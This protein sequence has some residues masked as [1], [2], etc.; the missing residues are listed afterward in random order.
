[1]KII[2][3]VA[4]SPLP[5]NEAQVIDSF[6]TTDD[7]TINA[8]SINI[9][10]ERFEQVEEKNM[11]T[12]KMMSDYT[13]QTTDTAEDIEAFSLYNSIGNKL[14]IDNG[15]I[16]IGA[17][18]NK[19]KVSYN[20]TSQN[21]TSNATNRTFTYLMQNTTALTQESHYFNRTG[22]QISVSHNPIIRDVN[23][24]DIFFLRVYGL[25]GGKIMG[26]SSF[27]HTAI[28]VEVIE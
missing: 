10:E 28:T 8:P 2:K 18:V 3:K 25:A 20:A 19:V 22:E 24:G 16:K 12:A 13:I 17:G 26:G 5:I 1:M 14:I 23:E 4:V 9:V 21:S 7:K 27:C 15:C 11:L 6:D